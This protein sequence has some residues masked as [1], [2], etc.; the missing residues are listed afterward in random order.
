MD[1]E[2]TASGSLIFEEVWQDAVQKSLSGGRFWKFFL[3]KLFSSP[4]KNTVAKAVRPAKLVA[5]S[6]W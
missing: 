5:I 3:E 6:V 1:T 4:K 2:E